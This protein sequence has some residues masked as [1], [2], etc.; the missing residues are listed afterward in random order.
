MTKTRIER[1]LQLLRDLEYC[2][3]KGDVFQGR[4]V[5]FHLEELDLEGGYQ[6]RVQFDHNLIPGPGERATRSGRVGKNRCQPPAVT[7]TVA[8]K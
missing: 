1:A 6:R 2:R 5:E 8:R 7:A 4:L 3:R